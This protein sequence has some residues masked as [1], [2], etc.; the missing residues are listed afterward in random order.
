MFDCL[1][2]QD[3][4]IKIQRGANPEVAEGEG[5]TGSLLVVSEW[6]ASGG[7]PQHHG[8]SIGNSSF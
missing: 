8:R 2:I 1:Q 4:S 6:E 3:Y 5:P 7:L